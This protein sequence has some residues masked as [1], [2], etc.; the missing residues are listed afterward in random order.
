MANYVDFIQNQLKESAAVKTAMTDLC[1]G[2]IERAGLLCAGVLGKGSK[3]LLCGNGGSAAD[4][5]HIATELVVR[6]SAKLNRKALPAL[7]LSANTSTL[8]A[9]ANDYGFEK[10]FSRQVEAFGQPGDLLIGISTSGNSENVIQA[11][12]TAKILDLRSICFLGGNG[13]TL[14]DMGEVTITIPHSDT[15]RIQEGHITVG[16]I[17]CGIIE[18]ELF[19]D[20]GGV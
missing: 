8:T 19:Q 12:K 20:S 6:L 7:A 11:L 14:S 1:S 16:H 10:I 9:C 4:A 2:D 15:G 5:Q 13:G 18:R 3:L 17:I